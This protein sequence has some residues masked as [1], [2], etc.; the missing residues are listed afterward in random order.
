MKNDLSVEELS[1]ALGMSISGSITINTEKV[2]GDLKNAGALLEDDG[3]GNGW[4]VLDR[5]GVPLMAISAAKGL[6]WASK[7]LAWAFWMGL[8]RPGGARIYAI[9][10]LEKETERAGIEFS[11]EGMAYRING[12]STKLKL[13][14]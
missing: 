6:V 1:Y 7:G 5:D 14:Q 4:R 11:G 10:E 12:P 9:S 3:L 8:G 13:V 2:V